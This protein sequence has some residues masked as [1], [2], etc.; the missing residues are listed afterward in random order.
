MMFLF[1]LLMKLGVFRIPWLR[2]LMF[3]MYLP[4]K[5]KYYDNYSDLIRCRPELF[6]GGFILDVGANI[7]CTANF[8]SAV[9]SDGFRVY[10]LEP[11]P[12]NYYLLQHCI[13]A[14]R[15]ESKI[16]AVK[17]AVGEREGTIR[18][19]ISPANHT[20]HQVLLDSH[21]SDE[22]NG[23]ILEVPLTSLDALAAREHLHPVKFVKIDVEGYEL[24][25]CQGMTGLIQANPEL[26][27]S[28]EVRALSEIGY[29]RQQLIEFF[30]SR[31]LNIY[32]V[33]RGTLHSCSLQEVE[34]TLS[35]ASHVDLLASR[36]ELVGGGT[37]LQPGQ[38]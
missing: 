28:F 12:E 14:Y 1:R 11:E 13:R 38:E 24:Q 30:T 2:N 20:A 32:V 8:L 25:V 34:R 27:V 10:A 18:M 22:T 16:V 4:L 19:R 7:G 36:L 35:N 21:V 17:T 5:R 3:R 15:N 6:T 37:E 9:V 23:K 33:G 31:S 29:E 26:V